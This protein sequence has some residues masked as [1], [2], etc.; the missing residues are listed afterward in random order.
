MDTGMQVIA[1]KDTEIEDLKKR[2]AAT[3][4]QLAEE[5]KVRALAGRGHVPMW[6]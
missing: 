1:G 4:K 6:E 2:L 3:E 5:K